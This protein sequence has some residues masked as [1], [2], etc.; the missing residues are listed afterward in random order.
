VGSLVGSLVMASL[1]NYRSKGRL[2]VLTAGLFG[3]FLVLFAYS[4]W[5]GLSLALLAVAG[6]LSMAYGTSVDTLLQT[7]A[8]DA[9]RGRVM[10]LQALTVGMSP[11]GGLWAGAIASVS[12]L[13]APFAVGL[14]GAIAAG[15]ALLM[16]RGAHRLKE[17]EPM[18]VA[19]S[20]REPQ[21]VQGNGS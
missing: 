19:S 8:P 20:E 18:P 21:P 17:P 15:G 11:L 10:G 1:G 16:A 5:F 13:G 2:L 4:P 9:M 6:A 12:I 14:G 7:L 3:L